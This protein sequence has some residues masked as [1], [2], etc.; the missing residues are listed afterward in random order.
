MPECSITAR[1]PESAAAALKPPLAA[2]VPR[3]WRAE[4]QLYD[5]RV[6]AAG[7]GSLFRIGL[8]IQIG[9]GYEYFTDA[10]VI[11]LGEETAK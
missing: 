5:L 7:L 10:F 11:Q 8:C 1:L 3:P 4:H 2:G 6:N 9:R